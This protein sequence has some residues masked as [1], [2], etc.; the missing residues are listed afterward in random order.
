MHNKYEQSVIFR[1]T[2]CFD[3]YFIFD[4]L[5][6]SIDFTFSNKFGESQFVKLMNYLKDEERGHKYFIKMNNND[7]L[8]QY[9][10]F[11][12]LVIEWIVKYIKTMTSTNE[13][14]N[15]TAKRDI[16]LLL[17]DDFYQN[18]AHWISVV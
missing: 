15:H 12:K 10:L 17:I 4:K 8:S 9:R 16:I 7:V 5:F 14:L 2:E 18:K 1:C 3:F 6:E 13:K 11:K